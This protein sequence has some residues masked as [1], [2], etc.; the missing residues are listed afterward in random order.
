MLP[1]LA[2]SL[3]KEAM[4]RNLPLTLKDI[5]E[6]AAK[7]IATQEKP[8]DFLSGVVLDNTIALDYFFYLYKEMCVLWPS[9]LVAL[10]LTLLVRK[11]TKQVTWLKRV[12]PSEVSSFDLFDSH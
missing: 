1:S 9:P 5:S 12:T 8:L 3:C 11:I 4:I 2:R 7:A 10:G 6:S